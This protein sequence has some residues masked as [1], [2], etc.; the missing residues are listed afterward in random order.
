MGIKGTF[1]EPSAPGRIGLKMEN[2]EIIDA[3][4]LVPAD[5]AAVGVAVLCEIDSTY[6][7]HCPICGGDDLT[8]EHVPPRSVGGTIRTSTCAACNHRLATLVENHLAGWYDQRPMSVAFAQ[9]GT[10]GTRRSGPVMVRRATDGKFVI[11]IEPGDAA[12]Q[13]MLESGDDISMIVTEASPARVE[14]ALLKHAYLAACLHLGEI[15]AGPEADAVR[16]ELIAVRDAPDRHQLPPTPLASALDYGR[17]YDAAGSALHL[18]LVSS[19][20]REPVLSVVLGSQW[21]SWPI[22]DPASMDKALAVAVVNRERQGPP[23]V[24]VAPP[25]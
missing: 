25:Q 17:S 22:A 14:V 18:A 8:D 1:I 4:P 7:E 20:G 3:G 12:V 9:D 15:P 6:F 21:V 13:E 2:G 19:H 10:Q 5:A 24:T 11:G 23:R 16:S